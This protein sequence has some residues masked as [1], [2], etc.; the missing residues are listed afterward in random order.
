MPAPTM[1][2]SS[3]AAVSGRGT[4]AQPA[5][6]T[7]GP[8]ALQQATPRGIDPKST[9]MFVELLQ[10]SRTCALAR[11]MRAARCNK[12][13]NGVRPMP[14]SW[15]NSKGNNVAVRQRR[16]AT[17]IT[18]RAPR[19]IPSPVIAVS[20]VVRVIGTLAVIHD[21]RQLQI[22]LPECHTDADSGVNAL[23]R[24]GLVGRLSGFVTTEP[25]QMPDEACARA[26]RPAAADEEW[27]AA[28]QTDAELYDFTELPDV[29]RPYRGREG[30]RRWGAN[31]RSVLGDFI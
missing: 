26:H 23:A 29:P 22:E 1:T 6:N 17:G 21:P 14:G 4:C 12:E 7:A 9:A 5:S 25:A 24:L 19:S 20:A 31:V 27:I 16:P 2:T 18:N 13:N 30:V 8:C 3:P 28:W 10:G 15:S 11:A